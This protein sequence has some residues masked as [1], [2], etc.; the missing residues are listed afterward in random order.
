MTP[1]CYILAV[2]AVLCIISLLCSQGAPVSPTG[3]HLMLCQSHSRCGDRFYDPQED[4][5]Y[6]DA[7]VPLSTS[8]KCGNCTFR[9]CFEQC[10]PWSFR[11]QETFVVKV[12]GQACSFGPFPGDRVCSSVR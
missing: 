2:W 1:R 5:C 11:P 12:R 7:V 6:D 8:R 9:I 3:A 10:C 4:C